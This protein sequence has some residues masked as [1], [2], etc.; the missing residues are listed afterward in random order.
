MTVAALIQHAGSLEPDLLLAR[1][2]EYVPPRCRTA[3]ADHLKAQLACSPSRD[4][5]PGEPVD[6][7]VMEE[8]EMTTPEGV[9]NHSYSD[10]DMYSDEDSD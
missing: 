1:L 8:L 9:E 7:M 10:E 2:P 6:P 5:F 4:L 3:I